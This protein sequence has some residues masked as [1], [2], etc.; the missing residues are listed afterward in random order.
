MSTTSRL[1]QSA[2]SALLIAISLGVGMTATSAM[3]NDSA[4]IQKTG[5]FSTTYGDG[6]S[7]YQH[8]DQD[9]RE[10]RDGHT[11]GNSGSSQD[12]IQDSYTDGYGNHTDQRNEQRSTNVRRSR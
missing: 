3:A 2:K 5:Q 8:T 10:I 6:N 9:H 4:N 11:R 12:N 7:T 1:I